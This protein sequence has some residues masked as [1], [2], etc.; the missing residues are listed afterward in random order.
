MPPPAP[1]KMRDAEEQISIDLGDEYEQALTGAS[2]EEI[3]D[4]AGELLYPVV[5][6]VQL[7][8]VQIELKTLFFM[9]NM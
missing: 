5:D 4:L 8:C 3:I 6:L 2:Q 9:P 7:Y 1:E